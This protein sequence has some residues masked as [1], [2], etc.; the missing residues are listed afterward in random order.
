M[1]EKLFSFTIKEDYETLEECEVWSEF[2][3]GHKEALSVLF[4]SYFE[5]LYLYGMN[6][7]GNEE[8]VKDAIQIL[9]FR[10]WQNR[11]RITNPDSIPAYLFVSLRRIML[12]KKRREQARYT[13]NAQYLEYDTNEEL[14]IEE[15]IMMQ[16]EKEEQLDLY[17]EALTSLTPRQK[18]ALLLRLDSGMKN[19]EIARIMD[20]SDKRVRNLIYEAK[21][22]LKKKL[23]EL[24]G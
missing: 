10:L 7:L 18:E 21:K 12:R 4:K 15:V 24:T 17:K 20:I 19:Q 23:Y 9:F 14:S 6:F 16:E 3:K 1:I 5:Q 11:E 8:M 13:R 22:Q 2:K